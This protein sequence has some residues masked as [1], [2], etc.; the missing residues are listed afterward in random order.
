MHAEV[1]SL[2]PSVFVVGRGGSPPGWSGEV[3]DAWVWFGW[4]S[5]R[6]DVPC[7]SCCLCLLLCLV[8]VVWCA[9]PHEDFV[10]VVCGFTCVVALCT[11]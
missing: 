8:L 1:H 10:S 4:S 9:D 3:A 11:G 2:C 7:V 5:L 6:C